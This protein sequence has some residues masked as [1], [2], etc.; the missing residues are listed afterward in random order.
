MEDKRRPWTAEED[1]LVRRLPPADAAAKTG[2]TL[3]AVYRRRG[4]L[5]LTR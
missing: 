4:V 2:R 1:E 5:W 3:N